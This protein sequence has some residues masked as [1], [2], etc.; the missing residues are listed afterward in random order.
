METTNGAT[1]SYNGLQVQFRKRLS[2]RMQVQLSYTYG[3]SIDSS[4]N[5]AGFGGGFASLFGG[6]ERGSSDYD[7]RHNLSFSG[8]YRLPA[9]SRGFATFLLRN[10]FLDWVA[11]A[12]TGLP[13]DV[14][15]VSSS[16][17][18]SSSTNS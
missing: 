13:F 14:Q 5:D 1:S 15:G 11:T 6:G 10:W 7:V 2:A 9:P 8:S 12:R 3:H 18:D 16:S 17:S 4:S